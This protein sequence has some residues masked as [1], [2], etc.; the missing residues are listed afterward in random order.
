MSSFFKKLSLNLSEFGCSY[1]AVPYSRL[2][3]WRQSRQRVVV[4]C[5][6]GQQLILCRTFQLNRLAMKLAIIFVCLFVLLAISVVGD[7]QDMAK[8]EEFKLS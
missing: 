4:T 2:A 5:K 1:W 8:F 7:A 3:T 6:L